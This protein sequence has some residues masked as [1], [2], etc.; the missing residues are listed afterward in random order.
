LFRRRRELL[1]ELARAGAEAVQELVRLAYGSD[2]RPGVVV[3]V[4]TAGDLLQWHPHLHLITTDAGRT[5][6]GSWHPVPEW[7][8]LRL[9]TLFRE[10]LL[11]KLVE[12]RAISKER[13]PSSS[14]GGIPASPLMWATGSL[15]KTNSASK[16]PPPTWCGIPSPSRSSSTDGQQAVLY[17]SKLN[18]LLGR[19]FEAMDSVEWLARMSDHIPDPGQH[20]PLFYGEYA[21]RI[22]GSRRPPEAE[23]RTAAAEPP[24]KR[25]SP[26]WARL[27]AKVYLPGRSA[28]LPPAAASA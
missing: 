25:C 12:K 7:D 8:G 14:P 1:K 17:R 5:K 27:I 26:S 15:P 20:R 3:F 10:R 22:R 21:N 23:Q 19:N 16:T 9:M 28:R 18:P 24:R 6:D 11:A 4:A 13:S 2:A